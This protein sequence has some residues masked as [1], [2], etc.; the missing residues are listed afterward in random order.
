MDESG[1]E[2]RVPVARMSVDDPAVRAAAGIDFPGAVPEDARQGTLQNMLRPEVLDAERH[3]EIR[4]HS[5]AISGSF[6]QPLVRAAVNLRGV[7]REIEM[8]IA[9]QVVGSH[10]EASGSVQLRQTDF[11]ITPFS[12]AGGAVQVA[13]EFDVRFRIVAA[14]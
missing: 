9:L 6:Q 12:V 10:I 8:P 13:D 7:T 5:V 2:I 11:G 4:V 14:R 3:P 1:F